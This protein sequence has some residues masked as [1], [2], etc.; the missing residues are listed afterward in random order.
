MRTV[1]DIRL[2]VEVESAR[3]PMPPGA[4]GGKAA[5]VREAYPELPCIRRIA[6]RYCRAI[7]GEPLRAAE[8]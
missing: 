5:V 2:T 4:D 1:V 6:E 8:A 7:V 3:M